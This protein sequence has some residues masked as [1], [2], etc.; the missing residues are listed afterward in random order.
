MGDQTPETTKLATFFSSINKF[1][2]ICGLPNF[3]NND[4]NLPPFLVRFNAIYV[5]IINIMLLTFVVIEN[6]S[7]ITQ[8][9]LTPKQK[10]DLLTLGVSH[11]MLSF[12]YIS[13]YLNRDTVKQIAYTLMISLKKH[14]NNENVENAAIKRS[15]LYAVLFL[16]LC[17]GALFSY[18]LE[19]LVLVILGDGK[20]ITVVTAFPD[21][22]DDNVA[23]NIWRV[24][25]YIFWWFFMVR[26]MALFLVVITS[27]IYLG[28]QY[29]NLQSYFYSLTT[30][31]DEDISQ[32]EKEMKYEQALKTGIQLHINT[33]RCTDDIQQAFYV[34]LSLQLMIN[35]MTVVLVMIRVMTSEHTPMNILASG[36]MGSA[37]LIGTGFFMWNMGDVTVEASKVPTAIYSS[38]WENCTRGS[39]A[40][41]RHLISFSIAQGQKNVALRA[42]GVVE[43][44]YAS[45]VTL[46]KSSYSVF[47]LFY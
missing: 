9:N 12:Y 36:V 43:L 41:V 4:Y 5:K 17:S 38:G 39:S 44:S 27:I 3:V 42:L 34:V 13:L 32:S 23:G 28:Y 22:E 2:Y 19:A 15:K 16:A 21:V 10:N 8:K 35:M 20:F 24:V 14:Y 6:L 45:Y 7:F 37:M 46:V 25:F 33:L 30:I 47:S 29:T 26:V 18:G 40:R 31:F 1:A 11:F